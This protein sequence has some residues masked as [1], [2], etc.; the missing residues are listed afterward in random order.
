MLHTLHIQ[1]I[2]LLERAELR[3]AEGLTAEQI[4]ALHHTSESTVR[5]HIRQVLS[6]L[7]AQ[8]VTD[9]VRMLRQGEAMWAR[10]PG[11]GV[12]SGRP[13]SP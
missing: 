6:K 11:S 7:G 12:A 8:R 1:N 2:A 4:G 3:L 13:D 5:S 10:G 9:V